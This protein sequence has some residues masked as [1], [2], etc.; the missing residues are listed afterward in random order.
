MLRDLCDT[1]A[2]FRRTRGFGRGISAIQ[3][4]VPLRLIYIEFEGVVYPLINPSG[5]R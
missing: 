1:L 5:R 2:E 4:G 3:I